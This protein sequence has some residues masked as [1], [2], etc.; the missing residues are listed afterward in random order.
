[1]YLHSWSGDKVLTF[2]KGISSNVNTI[3]KLVL[4]SLTAMFVKSK[5]V[6]D[7]SRLR[8]GF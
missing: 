3:G 5:G 8:R 7:P 2:P 4:E 6:L 1:M